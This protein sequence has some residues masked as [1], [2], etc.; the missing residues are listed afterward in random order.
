[1]TSENRSRSPAWPVAALVLAAVGA[2]WLANPGGTAKA[3][4]T[5]LDRVR[6]DHSWFDDGGLMAR[7]R[8]VYEA[9]IA[10]HLENG[11]GVPGMNPPLVGAHIDKAPPGRLVRVILQGMIGPAVI[12]GEEYDG[13]MAPGQVESDEDIA[14]VLTYI[15]RS[16]GN[17][18]T[19]VTP[20]FVRKVREETKDRL[21]PWTAEELT[22]VQE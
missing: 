6:V 4:N 20:E 12:A 21:D 10:C 5:D 18:G 9:C 11:K 2:A 16:W 7:G 17:R 13:V 15:R 3:P 22:A 14:A 19:L 1:M 8:R